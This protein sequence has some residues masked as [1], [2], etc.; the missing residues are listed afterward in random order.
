M[1]NFFSRFK[2]FV[3]ERK[4]LFLIFVLV[5]VLVGIAVLP[6]A[7]ASSPSNKLRIVVD[8][9]H[10]GIDGGCE[11][12]REGSNERELNL[13][14]A[15]TLK[16]YLE[17][18]GIEVVLTRS[19]TDGL[20]SALASNKK[21]DDMKKRKEII[22]KANADLIVSLHM[23]AFPQKSARGAQVYYNPESEVSKS[24]ATAIQ[25]SF[26]KDLPSAKSVPAVGDYYILNC[27]N[28]PAVIVECGFLSNDEEEILLLS[29]TYRDKVCYSILCGI[30]K[31]LE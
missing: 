28:T 13:L 11:G 31:Y 7:F 17:S 18:Y 23:N 1:K 15:K 22:E 29:S 20:Y 26:K 4:T 6:S 10:G 24:L 8:A 5:V 3:V 30:V 21:K 25:S 27:T 19:T 14:Y 9:G 12:S 16:T 2:F